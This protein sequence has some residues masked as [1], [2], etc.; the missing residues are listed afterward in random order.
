MSSMR[1]ALICVALASASWASSEVKYFGSGWPI[2]LVDA[3][4]GEDEWCQTELANCPPRTDGVCTAQAAYCVETANNEVTL[5]GLCTVRL[6]E[7]GKNLI[8]RFPN[9]NIK[10]IKNIDAT[11]REGI[12]GQHA[13]PICT[14]SINAFVFC[15]SPI[16]SPKTLED[17]AEGRIQP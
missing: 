6:S 15:F 11:L 9:G 16:T 7:D 14:S 8:R 5:D 3:V 13:A 10:E 12:R 2:R 1:L 4:C 17:W